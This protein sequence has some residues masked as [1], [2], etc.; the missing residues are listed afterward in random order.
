MGHVHTLYATSGHAITRTVVCQHRCS[1]DGCHLFV[2]TVA[3]VMVRV[4]GGKAI[5]EANSQHLQMA[6]HASMHSL[7][8]VVRFDGWIVSLP[9]GHQGCRCDCLGGNHKC[10]SC[11][12]VWWRQALRLRD[13]LRRFRAGTPAHHPRGLRFMAFSALVGVCVALPLGIVY[14]RFC[15]GAK[16]TSVLQWP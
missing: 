6:W 5:G 13:P 1:S 3:R 7:H 9:I 8:V 16:E 12:V 15:V 14:L 2:S 11:P 10:G 4:G